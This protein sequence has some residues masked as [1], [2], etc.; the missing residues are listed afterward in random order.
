MSRKLVAIEKGL[1][2]K[3]DLEAFALSEPDAAEAAKIF[4]ELEFTSLLG[5]FVKP[6]PAGPKDYKVILDERELR[7]LAAALKK[8][9]RFA[10][11]TETD[12]PFPT[13]ARLV[14][15][16]FAMKPGE[17]YYLPLRHEYPGAPP[18]IP[19][20]RAL[21]ILKPVLEEPGSP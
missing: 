2:L 12:S 19:V 9:G 4:Q 8:A 13:R 1:D 7:P 6:K 5:A 16:S 10:L 14:G 3:F 17:A 11:D 15:M 20:G 21:E 18:Q